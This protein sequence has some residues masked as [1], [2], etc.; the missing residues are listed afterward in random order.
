MGVI[1][2]PLFPWRY[3]CSAI[4][5]KGSAGHIILSSWHGLQSCDKR[6]TSGKL[7]APVDRCVNTLHSAGSY[8]SH[9]CIQRMTRADWPGFFAVSA[10]I[11]C[12]GRRQSVLEH[13][14]AQT[15]A[16]PRNRSELEG[17][18]SLSISRWTQ[19]LEKPG[20]HSKVW[21][22]IGLDVEWRPLESTRR[23]EDE[24]R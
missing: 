18:I 21:S 22:D 24:Q 12:R 6:T 23:F 8:H 5:A 20:W 17:A 11:H 14:C 16:R 4:G 15:A 7:L 3:M 19:A 1:S 9:A 2:D 10:A 13:S